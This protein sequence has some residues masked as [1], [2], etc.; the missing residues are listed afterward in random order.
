MLLRSTSTEG[1]PKQLQ[2]HVGVP[3]KETE[4]RQSRVFPAASVMSIFQTMGKGTALRAMFGQ[5]QIVRLVGAHNGLTARLVEQEGFQGVWASSLEVSASH[6]VPDANI[7][8]MTEYASAARDMNESV[9]IPVVVDAD[10]GYGGVA[11]VARLVRV[12]E[13]A[14]IAGVAIEDKSFPKA[15]S[16]LPGA[17]QQLVSIAEFRAKIMAARDAQRLADMMLIARTE[18]LIAGHCM[19]EALERSYAYAGAGADAI[20]IHSRSSTPDEIVQFASQ[21]TSTVPLAIVPTSYP[22]FTEEAISRYPAIKMVIYANPVIRAVIGSVR[23][24]LQE[25]RASGGIGTVSPRLVPMEEVFRLQRATEL[26]AWE[27]RYESRG[28]ATHA[29]KALRA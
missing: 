13:S 4:T 10:Q 29:A 16:L 27:D 6:A 18:A 15:N 9:E 25:I 21:W 1:P 7:L 23:S 22:S 12:L 2:D 11:Q 17:R 8:T 24:L 19:A 26:A 14:G 20:L 5:P 3:L 28:A